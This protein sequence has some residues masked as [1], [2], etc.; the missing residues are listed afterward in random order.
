MPDNRPPDNPPPTEPDRSNANTL[1]VE[2]Q[3]LAKGFTLIPNAIL[4]ARG[5]SRD[6]KMLYGILLSYAWQTDSCFPGYDRLM[7]DMQCQSQALSKYIKE[8]KDAQLIEV[9]RRGQGMTSLYTLKDIQGA[10]IEKFENQSP[11]SLKIK[12]LEVRKSKTNNTQVIKHIEEDSS[13]TRKRDEGRFPAQTGAQP[14]RTGSFSR[15][16]Q[17]SISAFDQEPEGDVSQQTTD[18]EERGGDNVRSIR[19]M[20]PGKSRGG[21]EAVGATLLQRRAGRPSNEEAAARLTIKQYVEDFGRQ[22]GDQ[23]PKS[24]VTRALNLMRQS[25]VPVGLFI[26]ALQDTYKRTQKKSANIQKVAD[27]VASPYPQKN[28]M[29]YFFSLLEE[30]LG[31]KERSTADK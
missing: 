21:V 27:G 15:I 11:S 6:A 9:Q 28:K 31:L 19:D 4:R 17:V 23:A 22:L 14:A 2:N 1:R 12:E 7:E 24:S 26:G 16:R 5:L 29:P 13:N 18:S 10:E 3:A 30:E 20:S 25:G 8:L